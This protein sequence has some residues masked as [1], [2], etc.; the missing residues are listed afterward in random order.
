MPS[1]HI[2]IGT[3]S[4]S[5]A[6]LAQNESIVARITWHW[7]SSSAQLSVKSLHFI[8]QQWQ[9]RHWKGVIVWSP[10]LADK[11][12]R[13]WSSWTS[14]KGFPLKSNSWATV[15]GSSGGAGQNISHTI[16]LYNPQNLHGCV[17]NRPKK[18]SWYKHPKI[19]FFFKP[20]L[21]LLI[22]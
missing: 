20:S 12:N 4:Q 9:S 22:I 8:L 21:P 14:S 19:Q 15:A 2:L 6:S 13:A 5:N 10:F 17:Q 16:H 7:N 18:F 11:M 3:W 1:H